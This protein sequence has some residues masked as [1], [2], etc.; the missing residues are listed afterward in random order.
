MGPLN[1][2]LQNCALSRT[3]LAD[4][5]IEAHMRRCNGMPFVYSKAEEFDISSSLGI[6][7]NEHE[8]IEATIP[9]GTLLTAIPLTRSTNVSRGHDIDDF[10]DLLSSVEPVE[11][12]EATI[13]N[14][15]DVVE[16]SAPS[17]TPLIAI[18][19]IEHYRDSIKLVMTPI[20]KQITRATWCD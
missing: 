16:T 17:T 4:N 19:F 3:K 13:V 7:G 5:G 10:D 11:Q 6:E 8:E 15:E 9:L 12:R 20:K 14:L 18:A 2:T 1:L